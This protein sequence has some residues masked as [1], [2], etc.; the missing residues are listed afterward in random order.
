MV[1]IPNQAAV[2]SGGMLS[3]HFTTDTY[4]NHYSLMS[5]IEYVLSPTAGTPLATLTNNDLYATPMN[6]FWS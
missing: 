1:V 3:G 5:T 2:A 6:D 4:Y